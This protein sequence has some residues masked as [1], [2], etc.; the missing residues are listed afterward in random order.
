[1][2]DAIIGRFFSEDPIGLDAGDPNLY[3]YVDNDPVNRVDPN[4][5]GYFDYGKYY[6]GTLPISYIIERTG[7]NRSESVGWYNIKTRTAERLVT[8]DTPWVNDIVAFK[9]EVPI[10]TLTALL[11]NPG[12]EVLDKWTKEDWDNWFRRNDPRFAIPE[13]PAPPKP[14][15]VQQ[16]PAICPTPAYRQIEPGI[17]FKLPE[18]RQRECDPTL[19]NKDC[20][21][22]HFS[23]EERVAL[24]ED[25]DKVVLYA[26]G[27]AI[28]LLP[29]I[30]VLK[31][32]AD[33]M[34]G[35]DTFT[36]EDLSIIGKLI[37]SISLLISALP[38]GGFIV[39]LVKR[40][41]NRLLMRM[42]R[43]LSACGPTA[44]QYLDD[45]E[46]LLLLLW[47]DERGSLDLNF[48][49]G[50][51]TPLSRE[52]LDALQDIKNARES[53]ERLNENIKVILTTPE[54]LRP[55]GLL[56]K[57][58]KNLRDAEELVKIRQ[59]ILDNLLPACKN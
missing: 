14:N 2:Y 8:S 37:A 59:Q 11:R 45:I 27:L 16:P 24:A 31:D 30:G 52:I 28:G 38:A 13:P 22:R 34:R 3:R 42:K 46:Q 18:T 19:S 23:K 36:N 32:A 10:G 21:T 5:L 1:M 50:D 43:L 40:A 44:R 49:R 33:L 35:K 6:L 12:S 20:E 26:Y 55:E 57:A 58:Y 47:K 39:R 54:G 15:Q 53:V 25:I 29:G 9:Y 41:L 56:E 7:P 4:G 51:L 48:G 17:Q